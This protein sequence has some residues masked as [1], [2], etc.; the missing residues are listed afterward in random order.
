MKN[1]PQFPEFP[2]SGGS[3]EETIRYQEQL[4]KYARAAGDRLGEGRTLLG[5]GQTYLLLG[6]IRPG[7]EC[8]GQALRIGVEINDVSTQAYALFHMSMSAMSAGVV[9][10]D[11]LNMARA[12]LKIF[13][14]IGDPAAELVQDLLDKYEK[15]DWQSE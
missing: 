8:L 4:L 11:S 10:S 1:N 9:N 2:A 15:E 7:T 12:A 3:L 14:R 6:K 13:E 5:M